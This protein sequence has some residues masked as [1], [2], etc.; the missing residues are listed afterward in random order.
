MKA[1]V[2]TA[3]KC[4]IAEIDAPKLRR[5]QLLVEVRAAAFNRGD[6][7]GKEGISACQEITG[8]RATVVGADLAG[9]VVGVSPDI[10]EFAIG[11]EVC[12]VCPGLKGAM[13]E[14]AAVNAKWAAKIPTGMGFEQAAA[15]PS[16]GVTA[17]AAVKK[18]GAM[19]GRRVLVCGTSGGVGQY[20]VLLAAE[21]GASVDAACRAENFPVALRCGAE[22]CI[23]YSKGLGEANPSSY[24][25]VI[26]VNG[27]FPVDEY[28]RLLV[29]GGTFV[30][31]GTDAIRPPI[32]TLPLR[33]N[34]LRVGLF[35]AEIA[36]G[37]LEE[38]VR[39]VD[40]APGSIAIR[41]YR[42]LEAA[43][44]V[45]AGLS[46]SRPSGKTVVLI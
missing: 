40:H 38:A 45:L 18:S 11:D 27:K 13:A 21:A 22:N 37:G 5:G 14:F 23:D 19:L 15:L 35:F 10:K 1:L 7:A 43:P 17:L 46:R 34:R 31:V 42:S 26:A 9:T 33:G 41:S 44:D 16:A 24:D 39:R 2:C 32:L 36:R 6:Y 8:S 28:S 25:A 12:A 4:G 30:A 29:P 20:A 3:N